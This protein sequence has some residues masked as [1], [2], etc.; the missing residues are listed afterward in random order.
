[1]TGAASEAGTVYPSGAPE[2]THGFLWDTYCSMF[3][4]YIFFLLVIVFVK[5]CYAIK[6]LYYLTSILHKEN[7][8]PSYSPSMFCRN[9]QNR[10]PSSVLPGHLS[11]H[12]VFCGIRIARCFVFI[13]FF[14]WSL[15]FCPSSIYEFW[16]PFWYLQSV[17]IK[18]ISQF[19][20]ELLCY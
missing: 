17:Q 4:F 14:F 9:L 2:F 18:F 20:K 16:L 12:T 1:M 3:C 7:Q 15:C 10:S 5:N 13:F 6:L 8:N 19:R 11:S